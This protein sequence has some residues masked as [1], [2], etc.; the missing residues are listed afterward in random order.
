M[1]NRGARE[2]RKGALKGNEKASKEIVIIV[3]RQ[4]TGH[5]NV[6]RFAPSKSM[7]RP[8][9]KSVQLRLEVC[10]IYVVWR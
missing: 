10:G 9:P 6:N 7:K 3:A 5:P 1:G 4:G 8:Q 2:I